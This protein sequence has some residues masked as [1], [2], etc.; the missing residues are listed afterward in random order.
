MTLP[1]RTV[2]VRT[3]AQQMAM[4]RAR[5]R[6][7]SI[8]CHAPALFCPPASCRSNI[9]PIRILPMEDERRNPY[10]SRDSDSQD[11]AARELR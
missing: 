7:F 10:C 6:A 1:A 5:R 4:A 11:F 8:D 3:D 9:Q 2:R